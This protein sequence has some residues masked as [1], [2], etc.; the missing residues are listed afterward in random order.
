M[1]I[2]QKQQI[3]INI[4][5]VSIGAIGVIVSILVYIDN[6]K[7]A[8]LRDQVSVLD[9]QIKHLDLALKEDDAKKRGIY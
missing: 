2:D 3:S 5:L 7:H 9:K 8:K 1:K 4:M 6:K